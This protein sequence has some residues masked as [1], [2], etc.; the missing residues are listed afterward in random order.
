M[1]Y[2]SYKLETPPQFQNDSTE[3][4]TCFVCGKQISVHN[5]EIVQIDSQPEI[6]CNEH[7][8]DWKEEN[9]NVSI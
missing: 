5:C 9:K 2:D 3:M 6:F 7:F 8:N 1:I 4:E